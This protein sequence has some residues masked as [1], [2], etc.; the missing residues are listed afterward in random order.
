MDL[1]DNGLCDLILSN[2]KGEQCVFTIDKAAGKIR[3]DRSK[4]GKI[5]MPGDYAKVNES[6]LYTEKDE[7]LLSLWVDRGSVELFVENGI[8]PQTTVVFPESI[9]NTITI[10]TQNG[11]CQA[12]L[13]ARTLDSIWNK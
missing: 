5:D 10:R 2:A 1:H 3:M 9:F 7:I 6:P 13:K 8:A 12:K 4:S 11:T